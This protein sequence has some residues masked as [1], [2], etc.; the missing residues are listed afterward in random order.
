VI[1]QQSA[2]AAAATQ[3][4]VRDEAANAAVAAAQPQGATIYMYDQDDATV[5]IWI[6]MPVKGTWV[7][8]PAT[9]NT[10]GMGNRRPVTSPR[11]VGSSITRTAPMKQPRYATEKN[12][13]P[14]RRASES[15]EPIRSVASRVLATLIRNPAGRCCV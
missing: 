2:V 5:H 14:E 7:L 13:A 3:S 6:E 1:A 12:H 10:S 15:D 11:C 9:A 8:A 4:R